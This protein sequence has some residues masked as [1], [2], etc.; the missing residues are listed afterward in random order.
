MSKGLAILIPALLAFIGFELLSLIKCNALI[1]CF[2]SSLTA[3]ALIGPLAGTSL[4]S[5][6]GFSFVILKRCF[7]SWLVAPT[8]LL[9]LSY[10]IPTVIAS[11]YW[12]HKHWWI[13]LGAPILCIIVFAM[14]PVGMHAMLY[15]LFWLIPIVLY[16]A[17]HNS[18][19]LTA[20]SATFV[21]HA[22]GSV[23]WLYSIPMTSE[24]WLGFP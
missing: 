8:L 5:I 14:H 2:H 4:I 13:R 3:Y 12:V 21:Q 17:P 23:L 24:Q 9:P 20:L 22:V 10:H 18:I 15:T 19:F 16:F 11:L 6:L 1:G 7:T